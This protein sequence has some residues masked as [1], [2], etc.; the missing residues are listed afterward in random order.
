MY[1]FLMSWMVI[2]LI[3]AMIVWHVGFTY[4]VWRPFFVA[5]LQGKFV[6]EVFSP[7]ELLV[8]AGRAFIWPALLLNR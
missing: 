4:L 2:A 8:N 6:S 1:D 7:R 3:L 5:L